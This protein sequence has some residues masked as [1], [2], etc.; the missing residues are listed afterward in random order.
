M[1]SDALMKLTEEEDIDR[2]FI[3]LDAVSSSL[4]SPDER[5]FGWDLIGRY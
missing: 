3:I 4:I 5:D 2:P 1:H